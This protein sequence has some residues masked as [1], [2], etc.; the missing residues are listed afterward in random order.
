MKTPDGTDDGS[1]DSLAQSGPSDGVPEWLQLA[2]RAPPRQPAAGN[3]EWV[4]RHIDQ[5][6]LEEVLGAGGMGVVF[7]AHDEQLGREVA[8]KLLP[9][10]H[11]L[12][13][14]RRARLV[15]E[16]RNAAAV[17]HP[18]IATVYEVGTCDGVTFVAFELIGGQSLRERLRRG[19]LG[20]DETLAVAGQLAGALAHVHHRGLVHRDIKPENVMLTPDGQVKL[21]DFGLACLHE[22][23]GAEPGGTPGYMSP[24]QAEHGPVGPAS[25]VYAWGLLVAE[26][27]TGKVPSQSARFVPLR[28]GGLRARTL[29][30]VV[31][32]CL[33]L[34]PEARFATAEPLER[35]VRRLQRPRRWVWALGVALLSLTLGLALWLRAVPEGG[36]TAAWHEKRVTARP[37][38]V[39]VMEAALSPDG[40]QVA[41]VD[42][43]G[44]HL[45]PLA[46]LGEESSAPAFSSVVSVAWR[47][48]R[49]LLVGGTLQ[50]TGERGLWLLPL[51]GAPRRLVEGAV[52]LVRASPDGRRVAYL[53]DGGLQWRAVDGAERGL[54]MRPAD[55]ERIF[56]LAWSPDGTRVAVLHGW[57]DSGAASLEVMGLEDGARQVVLTSPALLLESG[58]TALVWRQDALLYALGSREARDGRVSLYAQPME[59]LTARGPARVLFDWS[60]SVPQSLS[61]DRHGTLAYVR[62]DAQMDVEVAD[63]AD[64]GH[65]L[66]SARRLTMS[67]RN[68]RPSG[69]SRDGQRVLFV[70]DGDD[71]LRPFA[72]ALDSTQ[73]V[74][75]TDDAA[76]ESW[77]VETAD[78][79]WLLFWRLSSAG[80]VELMRRRAPG[81]PEE[82]LW[83]T[84][85]PPQP[86][87]GLPPPH[88]HARLRCPRH[89][90]ACLLAERHQGGV[91]FRWLDPATGALTPALETGPELALPGWDV[92]PEGRW[93]WLPGTPGGARLVE[94]ATQQT[95]EVAAP[96]GCTFQAGAFAA[97]GPGL[98][99]TALCAD[100]Q[101]Y[102]LVFVDEAGV[103]TTL[104]ESTFAWLAN[105]EP[106][107]DGRH[108]AFGAKAHD[109][110][111]WLLTPAR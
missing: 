110:D 108:L 41:F 70:S 53:G 38:E 28:R 105:P 5:F 66:E 71:H 8:L 97:T 68:E 74:A 49:E 35:A 84:M 20:F 39:P 73:A 62:L 42:G 37:A 14:A 48:D 58:A 94:L 34:R 72:Q 2:A 56:D 92:S 22:G 21:V 4:G 69:W 43:A 15:Q 45:K 57:L 87:S 78:G 98:F 36:A 51:G 76:E 33:Q 80:R 54:L 109:S 100:Q 67:D 27:L 31:D 103:A 26:M 77:P 46:R 25:D 18:N 52:A 91:T 83:S 86:E 101:P 10:A 63:L 47:S 3:A 6:R 44:L 30:R 106:S 40:Q 64:D 107:P 88:L 12:D 60:G 89:A 24:E 11:A 9:A 96:P 93:L 55:L 111:V 32:R 16:A 1:A 85:L 17:V 99:A 102:R 90:H 29:A 79:A 50:Q 81:S 13:E 104:R 7:R 23:E 59:G 19:P 95:R 75:L 61:A 65:R 82:A